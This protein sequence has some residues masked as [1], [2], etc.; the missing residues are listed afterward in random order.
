MCGLRSL[1]RPGGFPHG[2]GQSPGA[3]RG[4]HN[5]DTQHATT[6]PFL[7]AWDIPSNGASPS[8]LE[9][10][11]HR[12]QVRGQGLASSGPSGLFPDIIGHRVIQHDS[13]AEE[14]D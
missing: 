7:L 9:R 3:C 11:R 10:P 2:R 13:G 5:E 8:A 6:C 4:V 1:A 12:I 14:P